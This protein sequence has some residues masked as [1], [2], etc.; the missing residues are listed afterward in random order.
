MN[1]FAKTDIGRIRE[2]NQ[3]YYRIA[4]PEDE[5]QLYMVADGMGGYNGGEVASKLSVLSVQEFLK[6]HWKTEKLAEKGWIETILEEAIE[7]A[8]TKVYQKAKENQ[9]LEGMGTTLEVCVIYNNKVYIG[10]VGD[11]AVY[12]IRKQF[13]RKLTTDHSYVQQLVK[14]G[15]ISKEDA[16]SHPKKNMITKA[17]GCEE[18]VKPDILVKG[19]LKEDILLMNTD[20]LSNMLEEKQI[21]D[22]IQSAP[23]EAA[24]KLVEK[25]NE[26]GGYDN[27]TAVIIIR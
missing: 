21:Y 13:I 9:E 2:N 3:D 19:F 18:K 8:N 23:E 16:R 17:L 1:A 15:K 25:A 4:T 7:Y 11:S 10:H 6:E 22:I 20:G 24:S 27:I 26:F 12:R 14:D 5:L